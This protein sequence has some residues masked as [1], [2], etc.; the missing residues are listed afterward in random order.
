MIDRADAARELRR[1]GGLEYFKGLP[2]EAM[3]ELV[4]ALQRAPSL[5]VAAAAVAEWLQTQTQ[6]P[7]PAHLNRLIHKHQGHHAQCKICCDTGLVMQGGVFVACTCE[8]GERDWVQDWAGARRL[9]E[10]PV[11]VEPVRDCAMCGGTGLLR[12]DGNTDLSKW[13]AIPD[14]LAQ[15]YPCQMCADGAQTEALFAAWRKEWASPLNPT[16]V[17]GGPPNRLQ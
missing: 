16:Q 5:I 9:K 17:K 15:C 7:T 8:T 2:E 10:Q 6:R 4:L 14:M 3:E 1:L 12:H 13:L 11:P